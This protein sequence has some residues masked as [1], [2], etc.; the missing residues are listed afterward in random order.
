M[1]RAAFEAFSEIPQARITATEDL[2][3]FTI[4]GELDPNITE[5]QRRSA[6][7]PNYDPHSYVREL[8]QSQFCLHLRG[9]T[10]TSR[11]IFDAL[12]AG[13]VPV[14]IS[15]DAHLPFKSQVG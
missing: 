13:C 1:R 8:R 5:R 15:D 2:T 4:D 6:R 12:A 10:T 14:L 11:R 9:D 7:I 3:K